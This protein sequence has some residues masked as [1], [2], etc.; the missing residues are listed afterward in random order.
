[1]PKQPILTLLG[2]FPRIFVT[3]ILLGIS[4]GLFGR[5]TQFLHTFGIWARVRH[6]RTLAFTRALPLLRS[7]AA[8]M[9]RCILGSSA[10]LRLCFL[11]RLVARLRGLHRRFL[12]NFWLLSS[13]L[14][15]DMFSSAI[16]VLL[17]GLTRARL[18][19]GTLSQPF[20]HGR[21][22]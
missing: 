16:I 15:I 20:G 5:L 13:C 9:N 7:V 22:K 21:E 18:F 17:Y 6:I 1:M 11:L 19:R 3:K 2:K 14:L 10:V 4:N 12:T 8:L